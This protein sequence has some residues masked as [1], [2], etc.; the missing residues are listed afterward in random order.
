MHCTPN[1]YNYII[2]LNRLH[3]IVR[4]TQEQQFARQLCGDILVSLHSD[5]FSQPMVITDRPRIQ[6]HHHFRFRFR[7]HFR[8][9]HQGAWFAR[10]MFQGRCSAR[11]CNVLELAEIH[12]ERCLQTTEDNIIFKCL[13]HNYILY[14]CTW[15]QSST[16]S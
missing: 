4:L 10:N 9:H 14:S 5:T 1:V 3:G 8:F 2:R 12:F 15:V 13:Y 7:C 11:R 6:I 16:F